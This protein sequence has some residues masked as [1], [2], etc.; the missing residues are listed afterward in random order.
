MHDRVLSICCSECMHKTML[1]VAH[2]RLQHDTSQHSK[3]QLH[4]GRSLVGSFVSCTASWV[5]VQT[6]GEVYR[7]LVAVSTIGVVP[8]T[9]PAVTARPPAVLESQIWP[10]LLAERHHPMCSSMP[11]L[12]TP[13]S[14]VNKPCHTSPV[15]QTLPHQAMWDAFPAMHS[16][17]AVDACTPWCTTTSSS[18]GPCT[19]TSSSS[20]PCTTTQH[21]A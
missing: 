18:S 2:A 17:P 13:R 4:L 15:E 10:G 3:T 16:Q 7:R 21:Q 11:A 9:Q 12:H 6:I 20:G 19:T 5:D 1:L 14:P 8:A